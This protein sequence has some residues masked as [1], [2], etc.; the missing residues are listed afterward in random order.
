MAYGRAAPGHEAI[1]ERVKVKRA[2]YPS[3]SP[4]SDFATDALTDSLLNGL[5][6]SAGE[7]SVHHERFHHLI[8]QCR[9]EMQL[10]TF[11]GLLFTI[12][13]HLTLGLE[14]DAKH[15]HGAG[16]AGANVPKGLL[17]LGSTPFGICGVIGTRR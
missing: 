13:I 6:L 10:G 3:K 15:L 1:S 7:H 9:Q 2:P 16:K 12:Y 17:R 5:Q 11:R 8:D 14:R 4:G